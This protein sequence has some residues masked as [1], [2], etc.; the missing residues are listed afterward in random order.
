MVTAAVRLPVPP[1]AGGAAGAPAEIPEV[2]GK[3]L[4]AAILALHQ[5]GFRVQ[6]E[7]AGQ[8]TRTDPAAG[9]Q[10]SSGKTVVV[11]AAAGTGRP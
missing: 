1:P 10:L 2:R 5:R 11:Y 8:V 3:S 7:G 9:E 4:R 6:V